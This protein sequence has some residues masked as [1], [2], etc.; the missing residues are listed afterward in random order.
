MEIRLSERCHLVS[1]L[2]G[3]ERR[4]KEEWRGL[5]KEEELSGCLCFLEEDREK[6]RMEC[7]H[8][9]R[10]VREG[11]QLKEGAVTQLALDLLRSR[12]CLDEN[13]LLLLSLADGKLRVFV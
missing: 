10:M 5:E 12:L 8:P 9:E 7:K 13:S 4:K 6:D 1:W 11:R 2:T 3:R